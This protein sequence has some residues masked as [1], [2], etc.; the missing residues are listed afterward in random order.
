M[1]QSLVYKEVIEKRIVALQQIR[2]GME[3]FRVLD[4]F[5]KNADLFEPLI[6]YRADQMIFNMIAEKLPLS[7]QSKV[8]HSIHN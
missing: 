2:K 1:I 4:V 5:A 3:T 6:V 8:H 7:T